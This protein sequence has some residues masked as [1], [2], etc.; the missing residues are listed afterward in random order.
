MFPLRKSKATTASPA[1][2]GKEAANLPQS[3]SDT[4]SDLPGWPWR[5]AKAHLPGKKVGH[6]ALPFKSSLAH[7]PHIYHSKSCC[8]INQSFLLLFMQYNMYRFEMMP[9]WKWVHQNQL[10][11]SNLL[12]LSTT[13]QMIVFLHQSSIGPHLPPRWL[14][15]HPISLTVNHTAYPMEPKKIQYVRVVFDNPTECHSS[16]GFS[17]PFQTPTCTAI[18]TPR[19]TSTTSVNKKCL[20]KI[21]SLPQT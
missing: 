2:I 6:G 19:Y 18:Y 7:P 10:C 1:T 17:A 9:N 12:H 15:S 8:I 3:I 4:M 11:N 16:N 20:Q 21:V 14:N 5:N 13:Q